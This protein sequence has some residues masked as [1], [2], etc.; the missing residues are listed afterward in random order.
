M[1]DQNAPVILITGC[2]SGFGLAAAR[3]FA[4]AGWHVFASMRNPSVA[5][6]L[7]SEAQ[8]KQWLLSTPA[9]DVTQDASVSA[10]VSTLLA[11]TN[12]RLDVLVNNAGY[13]CFGP[14]EET[15]P[16]ELR[17]QLETNLVG[18]LRLCRAVLPTMRAC[19]RG[20]IINVS[21]L[22][23]VAVVPVLGPYHA[24]KAALEAL[25]QALHFEVAPFGVHVSSILPGPFATELLQK[26]VRVSAST[27]A[28]TAYGE[29]GERFVR[30]NAQAPR[31]NVAVVIRSIFDAA[32][33]RRPKARYFVGPLSFLSRWVYPL[34]P[35]WL[36]IFIIGKVFG[37][38]RQASRPDAGASN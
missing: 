9:L 34:T 12:G 1:S 29:L 10:A 20:R 27:E 14:V 31:G 18:A 11:E 7:R 38:R 26:Q 30:L 4:Q 28:S 35:Q 22:A 21:S 15:H 5:S 3:H 6:A 2:S 19:G 37:L 23:A 32:T 33:A 36:Y 17:A 16:D 24:S 8:T 13:F 25:S